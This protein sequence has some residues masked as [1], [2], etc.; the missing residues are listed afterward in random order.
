M[1]FFDRRS[2]SVERGSNGLR[3]SNHIRRRPARGKG[4]APID[5]ASR[6]RLVFEPSDRRRP[7][8]GYGSKRV[9]EPMREPFGQVHRGVSSR[10]G[11]GRVELTASEIHAGD[12]AR[13]RAP[14]VTR[15]NGDIERTIA[16][17]KA[18]GSAGRL[19]ANLHAPDARHATGAL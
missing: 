6:K 9:D 5:V 17:R 13:E 8:P 12:A 10:A 15:E 11:R 2:R 1:R 18:H 3:S 16:E 4:K 7:D 19:E 14:G